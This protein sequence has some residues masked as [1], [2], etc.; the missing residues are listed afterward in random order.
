MNDDTPIGTTLSDASRDK[1]P[2]K[3]P[4][5]KT[6]RIMLTLSPEDKATLEEAHASTYATHRLPFSV[7]LVQQVLEHLE[8]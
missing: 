7:W 1:A 6:E 2:L 4:K 5:L 8:G 3:R